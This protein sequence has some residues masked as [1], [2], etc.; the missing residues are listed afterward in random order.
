MPLASVYVSWHE[1]AQ[2]LL[3]D[4]QSLSIPR[5]SSGLDVINE[6]HPPQLGQPLKKRS[7]PMQASSL[8]E[9]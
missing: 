9:W 5:K 8:P 4:T 2:G 3:G 1:I 7:S 6:Q